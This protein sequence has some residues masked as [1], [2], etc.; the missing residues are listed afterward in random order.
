MRHAALRAIAVVGATA[1]STSAFAETPTPLALSD[2][3]E[4]LDG[5]HPELES[6]RQDLRQARAEALSA[7]GG[8]DPKLKVG[9]KQLASGY[10][11][12]GQLEVL[13]SQATPVWG[14]TLYTGWRRS[15]GDKI[16]VY[17]GHLETRSGG[18]LRVGVQVPVWRDGPIDE[19]RAKIAK[20]EL[21]VA[22]TE[23][24]LASFRLLL[25][26]AAAHAYWQWVEAGRKLE[27]ER[28]LLDLAQTRDEGIRRRAEKGNAA[29]VLALD[30]ERSVL[31]RR[32][33]VVAAER[34]VQQAALKLS[35]FYRDAERNPV[36]PA[37][38]RLPAAIPEPTPPV[39]DALAED[40]A[41]A[42]SARPDLLALQRSHAQARVEVR[43][44]ENQ[45]APDIWLWSEVAKDVGSGKAELEPWD[46]AVGITVETPLLLRKARG[47][48]QAARAKEAALTAKIRGAR[49]KVEAEIR[50]AYAA[51]E[52]A[53]LRVDLARRARAAA[54]ALAEAERRRLEL[55]SSDLLVLTLRET[56]A[57]DSAATEV[58]ALSTY[59]RALADYKTMTAE[60]IL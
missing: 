19:R 30:S 16:P 60:G 34:V 36:A 7:D 31:T 13:L 12:K 48:E 37:S 25:R 28:R 58:E 45:A 20:A 5:S 8:F 26:N 6:A 57:A 32:A 42:L 44:R 43:L 46:W 14:T 55:G 59:Q 22:Q 35:L 3:L 53:Y 52:A 39:A 2:V 11:D 18:E 4:T 38:A 41:R 27:I 23:L 54:E 33:R 47:E 9:A 10:Y 50:G 49:D 40:I 51:L 15:L 29:G 21:N 1:L 24:E 56:A 17:D